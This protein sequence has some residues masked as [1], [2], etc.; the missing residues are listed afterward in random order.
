VRD[1]SPAILAA[2]LPWLRR[3]VTATAG[4]REGLGHLGVLARALGLAGR[5]SEAETTMRETISLAAAQGDFRLAS[6]ATGDLINLL[7]DTGHLDKALAYCDELQ[8]YTRQAGSGRW[9]QLGD[10]A[11]R[12]QVLAELGRYAEVLAAV[13]RLREELH[14]LS[15][16]SAQEE[17]VHAL[18]VQRAILNAAEVAA[19]RLHYWETAL[20]LNTEAVAL[21][22]AHGASALQVARTRF[23]AHLPLLHLHRTLEAQT[24]LQACRAVFETAGALQAL[25]LLFGA[26]ASLEVAGNHHA[27]AVAFEKASL[28]YEYLR[29]DPG[30][31]AIG[32]FDLA[33]YVMPSGSPPEVALAHALAAGIIGFQIGSGLLPAMLQVLVRLFWDLPHVLSLAVSFGALCAVVEQ[34]EGV[35]FQ[36]LVERLP[37]R[38]PTGEAALAEVLRLI[39]EQTASATEP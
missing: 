22:E 25:G 7:R 14:A 36:K 9:A 37:C 21:Q 3:T 2:V 39:Q 5:W 1:A 16:A 30:G 18:G 31:C 27:A 17:M 20:A 33:L 29:G 23:N 6:A 28:H 24:L 8:V 12:L 32:H 26:L 34:V 38:A 11:Q 4:T 13:Q 15:E 19:A 10:E 35:R